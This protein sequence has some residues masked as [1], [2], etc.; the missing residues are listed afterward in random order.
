MQL[1]VQP[2]PGFCCRHNCSS[3][4]WSAFPAV[5]AL[6]R[7][8]FCFPAFAPLLYNAPNHRVVVLLLRVRL[9]SLRWLRAVAGSFS[10]RPDQRHPARR[11]SAPDIAFVR[12]AQL[13][14]SLRWWC[15]LNSRCWGY[16]CVTADPNWILRYFASGAV[17]TSPGPK[18]REETF[19][20]L[21][22]AVYGAGNQSGISCHFLRSCLEKKAGLQRIRRNSERFEVRI[23]AASLL[24][25][26][27]MIATATASD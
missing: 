9:A 21:P 4:G 7:R 26:S 17:A 25:T 13:S 15:G 20:Q 11:A 14:I 22:I 8:L 2:D 1:C 6:A 18:L 16:P 10:D 23:A 24:A 3:C 5:A 27:L 19:R 12:R